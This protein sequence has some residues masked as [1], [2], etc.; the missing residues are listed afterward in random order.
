MEETRENRLAG[1]RAKNAELESLE[2]R[3]KETTQEL[4]ELEKND[5]VH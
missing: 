1:L 3:D 4:N 5:L 2:D